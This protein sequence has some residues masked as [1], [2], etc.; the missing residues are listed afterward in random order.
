M[1]NGFRKNLRKQELNKK[2]I[3]NFF[4][5]HIKTTPLSVVFI[6]PLGLNTL[7]LNL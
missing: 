7:T 3:T 2:K 4:V 6:A 1:E 5:G